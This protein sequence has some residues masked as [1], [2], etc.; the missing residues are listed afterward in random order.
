VVV[1]DESVTA[2]YVALVLFLDELDVAQ[3]VALYLR[4]QD[5]PL[6]TRMR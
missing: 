1:R 6:T 5:I 3:A 2:G 4:R